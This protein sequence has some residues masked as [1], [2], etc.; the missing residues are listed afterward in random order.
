MNCFPQNIHS[1]KSEWEDSE[2]KNQMLRVLPAETTVSNGA[3]IAHF[4]FLL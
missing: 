3:L 1:L 2:G 4:L